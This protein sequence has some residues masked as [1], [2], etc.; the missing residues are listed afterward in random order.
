MHLT[1][2]L[3]A[4]KC[5]FERNEFQRSSSRLRF[6]CACH[7]V[8]PQS[9]STPFQDKEASYCLLARRA[10]DSVPSTHRHC[11][12]KSLSRVSLALSLFPCPHSHYLHHFQHF[13]LA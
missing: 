11:D 7:I 9:R 10:T 13:H 4:P 6:Q 5:W 2:V 1:S 12:T 8:L 3:A